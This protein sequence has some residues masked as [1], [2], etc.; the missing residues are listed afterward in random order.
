MTLR[1]TIIN[2]IID[3]NNNKN[4]ID[5]VI[6][7]IDVFMICGT[8]GPIQWVLDLR[9]YELKLYYNTITQGYIE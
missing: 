5:L 8:Q 3:N 1:H 9:T 7:I 4:C 2:N 6:L